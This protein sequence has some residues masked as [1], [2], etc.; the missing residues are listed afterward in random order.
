MKKYIFVFI[1]GTLLMALI[2]C[3][4]FHFCTQKNDMPPL[5]WEEVLEDGW[6]ILVISIIAGVL[7][8]FVIYDKSDKL[9]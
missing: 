8:S 4:D 2:L 1:C 9:D 3:M 5:S 6:V 7:T